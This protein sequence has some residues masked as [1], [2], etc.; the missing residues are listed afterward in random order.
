MSL[1]FNSSGT[2]N[3]NYLC[4]TNA[5]WQSCCISC[6][7]FGCFVTFTKIFKL[8][9][10]LKKIVLMQNFRNCQLLEFTA[11]NNIYNKK[12]TFSYLSIWPIWNRSKFHSHDTDDTVTVTICTKQIKNFFWSEIRLFLCCTCSSK[13]IWKRELE[14]GF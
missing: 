7:F 1:D 6:N 5:C 4:S 12:S 14:I 9:F 3:I 10:L 8:H 11:F 2:G 13:G